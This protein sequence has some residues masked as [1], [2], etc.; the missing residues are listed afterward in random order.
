MEIVVVIP[1]YVGRKIFG[2]SRELK[3]LLAQ[4]HLV[5]AFRQ[6]L[7]LDFRAFTEYCRVIEHNDS[8]PHTPSVGHDSR[9]PSLRMHHPET[10]YTRLPD[11]A[12]ARTD[13]FVRE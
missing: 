5:L 13:E 9:S 1:G 10:V 2:D 4:R 6:D 7:Y 11:S 8:I 3:Q 12:T